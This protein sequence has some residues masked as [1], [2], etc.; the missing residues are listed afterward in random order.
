MKDVK[1]D[2]LEAISLEVRKDIV[3]M[4]GIAR[5]NG[6]APSLALANLLVYLYWEWLNVRPAERKKPDRDRFVTSHWDAVPALYACLA[7]IGF[8]GREELWSYRR[9]GATLQGCPDLRTPGIDAPSGA[10]GGSL[11]IAVGMCL[12]LRLDN[13]ESRVHCLLGEDEL[14]EGVLWESVLSAASSGLGRLVAIIDVNRGG[15][16]RDAEA[17]AVS[18][19]FE[20]FGWS[21]FEVNGGDFMLLDS[22]FSALDFD[23]AK[24]KVIIARTKVDQEL[25]SIESLCD[26]AKPMSD[27]EMDHALSLLERRSGSGGVFNDWT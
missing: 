22:V 11:G 4:V 2:E 10:R 24:P 18:R 21:V 17:A 3:R 25:S 20:A 13:L 7:H 15:P 26:S 16:A 9:L 23:D 14:R 12:A 6:P 27:D 19:G 5:A 1:R 8:F